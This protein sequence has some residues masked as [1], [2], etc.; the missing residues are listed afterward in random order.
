M[1][2]KLFVG[3]VSKVQK[4]YRLFYKQHLKVRVWSLVAFFTAFHFL[5]EE[6]LSLSVSFCR[7]I[8]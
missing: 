1:D 4:F 7:L 8:S 5:V 6:V 2:E 3:L